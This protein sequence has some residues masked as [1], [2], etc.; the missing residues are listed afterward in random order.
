MKKC[1]KGFTLIECLIALAILG[2][3][4][5][6]MAEIYANISQINRNNHNVN[7]SLSY[8]MKVV[9]E[10]TGTDSIPIYYGSSSNA[11]TPDEHSVNSS[12][13]AKDGAPPSKASGALAQK[14]YLELTKYKSDGTLGTETYSFP[15]DIYVLLSRDQNN[16]PSKKYNSTTKTWYDNPNY[17][18]DDE[19][20][21]SLRYKYIVGHSN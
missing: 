10:A 19:K 20:D 14:N 15:V 21:Y 2:I 3:A 13:G 9:E 1:F 8:Q 5:L 12:T 11:N 16:E 6:V 18:G 4:S 17:N 7:T